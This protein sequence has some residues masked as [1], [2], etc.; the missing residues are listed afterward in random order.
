MEIFL[1]TY[2]LTFFLK[3]W[4]YF[5]IILKTPGFSVKYFAVLY[6][7]DTLKKS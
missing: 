4:N 7:L 6:D 5:N 3:I 1:K 2:L